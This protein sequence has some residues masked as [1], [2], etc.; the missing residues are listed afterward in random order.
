MAEMKTVQLSCKGMCRIDIRKNWQSCRMTTGGLWY[1]IHPASRCAISYIT[2]QTSHYHSARL[3][4]LLYIHTA[5]PLVTE[6]Y[7]FHLCPAV[8]FLTHWISNA[9]CHG[10]VSLRI[11][12]SV[13]PSYPTAEIHTWYIKT[14]KW[15]KN[16]TTYGRP[17]LMVG[18]LRG[19]E[20][21]IGYDPLV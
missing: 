17:P 20:L 16:Y 5:H 19:R 2:P 14:Q 6:L 4:I 12:T 13:D 8:N 7:R 21:G 15:N 11:H 1:I 3:S 9:L 18:G 10:R